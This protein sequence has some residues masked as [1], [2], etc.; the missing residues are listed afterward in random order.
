[1]TVLKAVNISKFIQ[2]YSGSGQLILEN[3]NF[4]ININE[5]VGYITAL[6]AP[7]GAGKTTLFK[8]LSAVEMPTHGN[9]FLYEKVY[10]TPDGSI[11]YI[12]ESPSSFPWLNVTQNILFALNLKKTNSN[13]DKLNELISFAGL[14]GYENHFP[15][16]ESFGFR[17][18]ISLARAL[19]VEPKVILLDDPLKNLHGVTKHEIKDLIKKT[20]DQLKIPLFI[21]T[22]NISEALELSSEIFLMKKHP[23]TIID[24]IKL[25]RQLISGK[26]EE[27][28]KL[29]KQRIE[30][31]FSQHEN[32]VLLSEA[33]KN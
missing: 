9:V 16:N 6:L 13:K 25:N 19:A 11:V 31:S 29:L 15:D 28:L 30:S 18:R 2:G 23:G 27:Y 12:P 33:G 1:M 24:N 20:A 4:E 8:I 32:S 7:L 14:T 22:T 17:F 10:N 5:E 21:S 3:I 26:D